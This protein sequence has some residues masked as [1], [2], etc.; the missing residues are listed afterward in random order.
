MFTLSV[1]LS[2]SLIEVHT[3]NSVSDAEIVAE[4][5]SYAGYSTYVSNS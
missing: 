1:F 2:N 4:E 3:F 5:M